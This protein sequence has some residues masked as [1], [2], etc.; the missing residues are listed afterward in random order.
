[1]A[2]KKI[3]RNDLVRAMKGKD[4][5]KSGK[6]IQ[7]FPQEGLVVVEGL[8]IRYK[9]LKKA[10]GKRA[11]QKIQFS[12]PMKVENIQLVCPKCQKNVRVGLKVLE[13]GDKVRI[14]KKCK[15]SI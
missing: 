10:S 14:C 4:R 5:G 8:N 6:V 7:L 3:K 15:E 11:G 1:M 13:N 9:H 2:I 12:A